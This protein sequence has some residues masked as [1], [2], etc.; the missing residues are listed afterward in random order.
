LILILGA[1][2]SEAQ[3]TFFRIAQ[4]TASLANLGYATVIRV[5]GPG[6]S[7]SHARG[8][9]ARLQEFISQ[10][11]RGM[12]ATTLLVL[13]VLVL[14][15]EWLLDLVLGAEFLPAYQPLILLCA[16]WSLRAA[17]GPVE[18]LMEMTGHEGAVVRAR[19][20]SVAVMVAGAALLAG[21]LGALGAAAAAGLGYLTLSLALWRTARR[22][23]GCA[24]TALGL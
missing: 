4:R 19:L 16:A 10:G 8:N 13:I 6:I 5:I 15:G 14:A 24:S 2:A 22:R 7:E 11:A 12:A 23:L 9:A 3:A 17:F 21:P 20:L 18:S 1:T